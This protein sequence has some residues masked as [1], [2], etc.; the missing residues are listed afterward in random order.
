MKQII[1]NL[2][3][4]N[5]ELIELPAPQVRAGYVLIQTSRSLVSLGSADYAD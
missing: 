3:N 2:K 5:T 4:G 1:Q